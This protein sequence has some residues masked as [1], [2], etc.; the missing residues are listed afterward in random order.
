MSSAI[1][2]HLVGDYLLQSDVLAKEKKNSSWVCALHCLIW[3][4]CV[5]GLAGWSNPWAAAVLFTTHFI[6][7]RGNLISRWMHFI[8]QDDFAAG[9]CAPW[10][11]IV[12]DNV[13]HLL[14]VW[15]VWRLL[16]LP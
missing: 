8:G 11:S 7:D 16:I 4:L 13:W 3:T 6:Q 12:V 15:L 14:T 9:P 5:C 1:I 2:G 10:S